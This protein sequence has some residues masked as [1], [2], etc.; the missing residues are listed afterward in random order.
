MPKQ[1]MHR[2][3]HQEDADVTVGEL[4]RPA[5]PAMIATGLLTT[6]LVVTAGLL[7]LGSSGLGA[8]TGGA[9]GHLAVSAGRGNTTVAGLARGLLGGGSGRVTRAGTRA[10][11]QT[12]AGGHDEERGS[13]G[14]GTCSG[15]SHE[16][17]YAVA[18]A[19]TERDGPLLRVRNAVVHGARGRTR[20]HPS[21]V[22][23]VIDGYVVVRQSPLPMAPN[24]FRD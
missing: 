23:I 10:G 2:T 14:L 19:V 22:M 4:I 11:R 9:T 7:T 24:L 12:E 13:E 15:E 21:R 18:G 16:F 6:L 3:S 17:S 20:R 8:S 1:S 5:R